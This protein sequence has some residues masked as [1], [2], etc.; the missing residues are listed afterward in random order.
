METAP[1]FDF[2]SISIQS[3]EDRGSV[4]ARTAL[5][6]SVAAIFGYIPTPALEIHTNSERMREN[7]GATVEK[8]VHLKPGYVDLA[9]ESGRFTLG[10]EVAHAV[11]QRRGDSSKNML[12]R[13]DRALLESEADLAGRAFATG[14]PF[15]VR[16][17]APSGV[18]LYQDIASSLQSQWEADWDD[19][20]FADLHY[21]FK[22]AGRPE[23][24]PKQRYMIL[25]GFYLAHEKIDRPLKYIREN[26]V[27]AHFFQ[28]ST[29]AHRDVADG[30]AQAE[31]TLRKT[32]MTIAP[33]TSAYAF[34]PR[35]QTGGTRWSNHASGRAIDLDASTN[36]HLTNQTETL[37]ISALT[38][39]DMESKHPGKDEGL[40]LYEAIAEA[41]E[42]FK[43]EFNDE[44]LAAAT[45]R[46]QQQ[47]EDLEERIDWLVD[48]AAGIPRGRSASAEDKASR[49]EIERLIKQLKP[50]L[51][52]AEKT[53]K[54][55]SDTLAKYR[56][57]NTSIEKLRAR[58]L[59]EN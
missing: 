6:N 19:P 34:V 30:L 59:S 8:S 44:G 16:G 48:E 58:R 24:T 4:A 29:P 9:S 18:T 10:H 21:H 56:Q 31:Q 2:G 47:M 15:H 17:R 54:A 37:V 7:R 32:G 22:N 14:V 27:E 20:A 38:G 23:G 35:T 53:H 50:D 5:N 43:Q 12:T 39:I 46:Y 13:G 1:F 28:F 45:E 52:E 57:T 3:R 25:C 42:R 49:A 55:L 11:Q 36:P 41:S 26:I 33:L 51:R 40:P